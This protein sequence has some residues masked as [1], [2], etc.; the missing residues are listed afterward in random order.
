M[1]FNP[2]QEIDLI[3]VANLLNYLVQTLPLVA[4]L[5]TRSVSLPGLGHNVYVV[6]SLKINSSLVAICLC[7]LVF[8][9]FLY[10]ITGYRPSLFV[11]V[12]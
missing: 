11:G 6:L 5:L 8:L 9:S 7:I 3:Q 12:F 1:D 10:V 4:K 2:W